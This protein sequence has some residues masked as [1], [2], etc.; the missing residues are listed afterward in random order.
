MIHMAKGEYYGNKADKAE[1][2][3]HPIRNRFRPISSTINRKISAFQQGWAAMDLAESGQYTRMQSNETVRLMKKK[4]LKDQ[5]TG[6]LE[7][8]SLSAS[9]D[10][11]TKVGTTTDTKVEASPGS[12]VGI[13]ASESTGSEDD[14]GNGDS[15]S[16][17]KSVS[18]P[19]LQLL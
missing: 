13:G 5:Q 4:M 10:A 15:I 12:R 11:G 14:T 9:M 19:I 17:T 3:N 6:V 8:P 7:H 2:S 18:S 16:A 1:E